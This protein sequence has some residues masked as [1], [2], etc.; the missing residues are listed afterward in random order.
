MGKMDVPLVWVIAE[1]RGEDRQAAGKN[2]GPEPEDGIP[3]VGQVQEDR[4]A[5]T[6]PVEPLDKFASA[7][8]LGV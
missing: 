2:R 8:S 3:V 5:N 1:R 7:E 6:K 4:A